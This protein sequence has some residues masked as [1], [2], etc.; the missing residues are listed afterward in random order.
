MSA[1]PPAGD[2]PA[3]SPDGRNDTAPVAGRR[4]P[5][6]P[7]GP[8]DPV[9]ADESLSDAGAMPIRVALGYAA[10][11]VTW[12]L[13][14]D[15]LLQRGEPMP[16]RVFAIAIGKGLSFVALSS[17]LIYLLVRAAQRR[18]LESFRALRVSEARYRHL[19]ATLER[20]VRHR[21]R[22]LQDAAHDIEAF[23]YS[24]SHD[25]RAPLRAI[26]GF[27][28]IL[29]ERAAPRLESRE[30]ELLAR[31]REAT[32]LMGRLVDDLLDLG[33]IGRA[34]LNREPVDLAVVA[35]G[36]VE[37][38]RRSRPGSQVEVTIEGPLPAEGDPGL[39][40]IVL[41][42]LIGNAWKFTARREEP[43]I[44]IGAERRGGETEFYVRDNGAGFDPERARKMFEPFQRFHSQEEFSGTGIGLATVR[45]IVRRHG[46]DIRAEGVPG[47]GATFRFTVPRVEPEE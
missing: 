33:R 32:A 28:E 34:E 21:T 37:G 17:V 46:G 35:R 20:R 25:L 29:E 27:G 6:P 44:W 3:P 2:S 14:S 36:I 13:V 16:G 24:V 7:D 11:G 9:P 39:L 26:E 41:V 30:K 18:L 23:S 42:N 47:Q 31:I 19:S 1:A 10:F 40:R 43:R 5:P 4:N 15:L 38:L 45:R 12:I 8:G 22:E